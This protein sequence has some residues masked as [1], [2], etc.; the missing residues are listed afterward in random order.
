MKKVKFSSS[1][2]HLLNAP[3]MN[4]FAGPTFV[5]LFRWVSNHIT[6]KPLY[7]SVEPTHRCNADCDFCLYAR[8]LG[9][10]NK[11]QEAKSYTS[12]LKPLNPVLVN[13]AGG[14]PLLRP[15]LE[16]LVKET[17][18]DAGVPFV[19]VTTNG[20]LLS[21]ERYRSL[22]DAGLDSLNISLDFPDSTHDQSRKIP[23]LFE[24]IKS[25]LAEYSKQD[26][27]VPVSLNFIYMKENMEQLFETAN[28]AKTYGLRLSI[29][30]YVA[31]RA[32][33][34]SHILETERA[35]SLLDQ[36][37]KDPAYLL[38]RNNSEAYMKNAKL[39]LKG[40]LRTPCDAGRSFLW[41]FPDGSIRACNITSAAKKI[42][43][44]DPYAA[45]REVRAFKRTNNCQDCYLSCRGET[46]GHTLDIPSAFEFFQNML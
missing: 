5:S 7:V 42:S 46:E 24:K 6:G 34:F 30:P 36:F 32:N 20:S 23:G 44:D 12:V 39:Y 40:E 4:P 17:K 45:L 21:M 33:N 11:D 19:S 28:F 13:F 8:S 31:T 18:E 41:V 2:T 3:I 16:R 35:V 9:N 15:D 1:Y 37:A 27:G 10:G 43:S 29:L 26:E 25:F 22:C 38:T 14:E